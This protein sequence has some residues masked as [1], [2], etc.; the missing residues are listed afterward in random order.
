MIF[1]L[2]APLEVHA[3]ETEYSPSVGSTVTLQ[4]SVT[5]GTATSIKWLKNNDIIAMEEST[6]LT[7]GT[8]SHPS[9]IIS[10]VEEDD[11]GYYI[12]RATN[13]FLTVNTNDI[14]LVPKGI[15]Y[16]VRCKEGLLQLVLGLL[17]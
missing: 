12:C 14:V 6:R 11:L 8:I 3:I 13:G 1:F 4:C 16:N 9:L 2:Q 10:S 7:G 15:Y 17:Y 5:S